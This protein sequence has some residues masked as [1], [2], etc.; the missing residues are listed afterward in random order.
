MAPKKGK[1]ASVSAAEITEKKVV[2]R[3][4][5]RAKVVRDDSPTPPSPSLIKGHRPSR[6]ASKTVGLSRPKA[7]V[8][9]PSPAPTPTPVKTPRKEKVKAP[10][11]HVKTVKQV[12]TAKSAKHVSSPLP[13]DNEDSDSVPNS[14]VISLKASLS[15]DL[16]NSLQKT[17]VSKPGKVGEADDYLDTDSD[18]ENVELQA[19]SRQGEDVEDDA[20]SEGSDGE[21]AGNMVTDDLEYDETTPSKNWW[22]GDRETDLCDLWAEERALYVFSENQHRDPSYRDNCYKR[23]A[24]ILQIPREYKNTGILSMCL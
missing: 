11:K 14:E 9:T 3:G 13:S 2:K 12:K 23:F 22:V 1:P 21:P 4:R 5:G 17:P 15:V 10:V 24:A 7:K 6:N 8:T 18:E 19:H 20:E 16:D